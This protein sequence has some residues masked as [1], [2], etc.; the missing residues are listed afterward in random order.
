MPQLPLAS[1]LLANA[2]YNKESI[3]AAAAYAVSSKT[4]FSQLITCF[5][6]NEYRLVQRASGALSVAALLQPELLT[7]YLPEI[8]TRLQQKNV[9][10][11]VTRNCV[12]ILQ[13]IDLPEALHGAVMNTCFELVTTPQTAAA[14]KAFSLT[15]LYNLSHHYPEIK[16]ELQLVIEEQW[17]TETA[18]FRS[19]GKKILEKLTKNANKA[20]LL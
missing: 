16:P 11:A 3:Q 19:R 17:E 12:R 10:D 2:A 6:G 8:V 5:L 20:S 13:D 4:R 9:P 1:M 7:P 14:I 18:A 15:I